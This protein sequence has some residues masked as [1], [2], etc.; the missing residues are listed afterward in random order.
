MND[1]NLDDICFKIVLV[2]DSGVGKSA[3]TFRFCDNVFFAEGA[4]T[5]GVDFKYSRIETSEA[6]P[7]TAR[8]Q[9]WDTAGQEAFLTLTTGF[10]RSAAGVVLCF[11]ITNR[12][13]FL[14]LD[15]WMQRI[16]DNCR[17]GVNDGQMPPIVLVGCKL[18]LARYDPFTFTSE[19]KDCPNNNFIDH[20][21]N[22]EA[23]KKARAKR[24]ISPNTPQG[25]PGGGVGGGSVFE[26]G[27]MRVGGA[28]VGNGIG[29]ST[30][31]HRQVSQAEASAWCDANGVLCYFETS[32]K[33]NSHVQDAFRYITT[34]IVQHTKMDTAKIGGDGK[35]GKGS[36]GGIFLRPK[37]SASSPD[38]T[39]KPRKSKTCSC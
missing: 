36:G 39:D 33:E 21:S 17:R 10:Y 12:M 26:G 16:K 7:R 24:L 4:P 18:D 14:H 3:V 8:L 23:M 1:I 19:G 5:L 32:A 9:I 27:S 22:D 37:G 13:S 28:G 2:G 34:Y 15:L 31:C 6:K 25:L 38:T 30:F 11:D 29:G 35:G 20:P